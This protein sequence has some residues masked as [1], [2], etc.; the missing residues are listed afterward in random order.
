MKNANLFW[1]AFLTQLSVTMTLLGSSIVLSSVLFTLSTCIYQVVCKKIDFICYKYLFLLVIVI[2][3]LLE[4]YTAIGA[5][6]LILKYKKQMNEVNQ[7]PFL[8][9]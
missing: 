9:D 4:I 8:N 7:N 6:R 5:I 2:W 3:L 1:R